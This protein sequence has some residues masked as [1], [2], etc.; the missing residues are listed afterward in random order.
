[1]SNSSQQTD[2]IT[3]SVDDMYSSTVDTITITGDG[4]GGYYTLSSGETINLNNINVG[5]IDLNSTMNS[6]IITSG[7]SDINLGNITF[8]DDYNNVT[9]P[10]FTN[11]WVDSFPDWERVQDMCKKYPGMEI[12]LRNLRT[13]YTLVKDDY[14]NSKNQE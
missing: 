4:T 11:E 9:L 6:V 2:Y 13:I 10:E 1:M 7:A 12:A 5:S 3:T 14:D 8:T